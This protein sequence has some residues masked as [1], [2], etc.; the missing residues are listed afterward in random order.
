METTE[1]NP[2]I[3]RCDPTIGPVVDVMDVGPLGHSSTMSS[4]SSSVD[5]EPLSSCPHVVEQR[6]KLAHLSPFCHEP[7]DLAV[8]RSLRFQPRLMLNLRTGWDRKLAAA[9]PR[10][11]SESV[12]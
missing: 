2:L 11:P 7:Y 8:T 10:L 9:R 1:K 5:S 12:P 6:A 4:F 3:D